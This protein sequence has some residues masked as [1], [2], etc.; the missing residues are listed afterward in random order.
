MKLLA[1]VPWRAVGFLVALCTGASARAKPSNQSVGEI[2]QEAA[3]E[4]LH[5]LEAERTKLQKGL[6]YAKTYLADSQKELVNLTAEVAKSNI[7][8]ELKAAEKDYERL[9]GQAEEVTAQETRL[10]KETLHQQDQMNEAKKKYRRAMQ[11]P[12]VGFCG[13]RAWQ[14]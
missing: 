14:H 7:S 4:N 13:A 10:W 8:E 9:H 1:M 3:L 2:V 5:Q 12:P 6:R 11:Q